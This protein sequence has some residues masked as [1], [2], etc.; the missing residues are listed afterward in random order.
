M[1]RLAA[2]IL[3]CVWT[4]YAQDDAL[5]RAL[6]ALPGVEEVS[7]VKA[8][9]MFRAAYEIRVR[10]PLD[11]AHPGGKSFLQSVYVDH[12][13]SGSPVVLETEGY[14]VTRGGG[15]PRE[16]ASILR[17]NQV[18]VEHRFFGGSAPD[19]LEWPFL[20][21][22]QAAA[23]HHHIRVLLGAIYRGKWVSS[24]T[25]KGGQTALFYRY[26]YPDD[27]DATV[28]YVAPVNLSI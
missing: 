3:I 18:V 17:C 10:Q 27:V 8:D 19:S 16:L 7:A 5:Y 15:R 12:F 26:Y 1:K 20:T 11:H 13:D 4:A 25:S 9:S 22:R 6:R 14:A 21:T 28:A 24:G 23:D 2:L